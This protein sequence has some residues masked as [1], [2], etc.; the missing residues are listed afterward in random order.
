[1]CAN[2]IGYPCQEVDVSCSDVYNSC[3]NESQQRHGNP[4]LVVV[5]PIE[6]ATGSVRNNNPPSI[7]RWVFCI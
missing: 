5:V 4:A 7:V 1:M 3:L 2:L 6:V